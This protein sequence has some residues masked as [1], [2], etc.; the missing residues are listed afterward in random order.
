MPFLRARLA[1]TLV[2]ATIGTVTLQPAFAADLGSGPPPP[3][4]LP[5]RA[6]AI[7]VTP[8]AWLP[9]LQGDVT[10]K[11]RS[12]D[13]DVTPTELLEHL[14]AVPFMGYT[15]AR[16]GPLA[17]YNDIFFAKVGVDA[18]VSRAV[19]GLTVGASADVDVELAII[20][21]GGA[22]E[23]ARWSS[24]GG[25]GLKDTPG[26]ARY[27]ALDLLAG[28]R[29]WH[30]D[31]DIRFGLTG[32]LDLNGLQVSRNRAIARGGDVDW[33]DPLVGFRIRH[34]L[35]P[36]QELIFRADIGGFDVGSQFSWN[37]LG[38]YSFTLAVR[39]GVTYSGLL[40]YRAL[41]VDYEKGSGA[42]KYEY[43]V[44]QHGPIV[45]LTIGF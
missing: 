29:Y 34:G 24:G 14:D 13:I 33:V 11:G 19:R 18:S 30:Q 9:F 17:L 35:A 31:L 10:I 42:N 7:S 20:E 8:Y 23:V 21:V 25:G 3:P 26:F 37:V 39:D 22:F 4:T 38:A 6:W 1:A 5:S 28:A 15:E 36:G 43:D 32:T 40:G 44:V 27:T 12:V 45:G 2:L 41:S 16:R